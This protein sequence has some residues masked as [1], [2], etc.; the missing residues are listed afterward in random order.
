AAA[1]NFASVLEGST[2]GVQVSQP[3]G[4]TGTGAKVRIR[5]SSSVSLSNE[6]LIVIDGVE[7][8]NEANQQNQLGTIGVGGQTTSRLNDINP[9]EIE[10]I[11][12]LQG[13]AATGLY[14]TAAANG[15]IVITT[16]RGQA[17]KEHWDGFVENGEIHDQNNYPNDY[18]SFSPGAGG[19]PELSN[20]P[21]WLT[22][23][24]GAEC[25]IDSVSHF[26]PLRSAVT[27]IR[28]GRRQEYDL[29]TSGG[30]DVNTFYVSGDYQLENGTNSA[31]QLQKTNGR[32][33]FS[34]RPR[35]DLSLSFSGGYVASNTRLPQNDN[36]VLGDL[37][38]GFLGSGLAGNASN[39]FGYFGAT[40]PQTSEQ[41]TSFADIQ[42]WTPSVTAAYNPLS[43]LSANATGGFD[44]VNADDQQSVQPN[45]V[46]FANDPLGFKIRDRIE[47]ETYTINSNVV[48]TAHLPQDITA[49]S[50]V[51]GSWRR[52]LITGNYASGFGLTGGANSLAA[53]STLQAVGEI[54]QDNRTIGGFVQ[55]QFGWRDKLF[56]TGGVRLDKNSSTGFAAGTTSYPTATAAYVISDEPWFPKSNVLSALKLRAA[57]GQSGLHPDFL[58]AL[59]YKNPVPAVSPLGSNLAAFTAGNPGNPNLKPERTTEVET[60]LDLSLVN[61]RLT[62]ST[63]YYD[64]HTQ[65][66]LIQQVLVPSIGD[67]TFRWINIGKVRNRGL[68]L[69]VT[70]V[71][72]EMRQANFTISASFS[73]NENRLQELGA[74]NGQQ[75][76][77][78]LFGLG[79]N[80]Q[81]HA[82]GFPL[83]GYWQIPY[84]YNHNPAGGIETPSMVSLVGT[85][86]VYMG[87]STPTELAT[88]SPQLTL[89]KVLRF[90]SLF[91]FQGGSKLFNGT[92][93]YRDAIIGNSAVD[94]LKG[95]VADQAAAIA[96]QDLGT[97][98][99]YF[100]DATFWKWR[101]ASISALL[102][103][104]WAHRIF[105]RGVTLT[106]AVRN[107]RT[108]TNYKG[109]D[110]EVSF[111]G[112]ANYTLGDFFTQPPVRYYT[113]RATLNY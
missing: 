47:T 81:E 74:V 10:S 20:C 4:T 61:D 39:N 103:T 18:A 66:A 32:A 14:G 85:K 95:N 73:T 21:I 34:T 89:F 75:I 83:G 90:G 82:Q 40:N 59:T 58:N 25:S 49:T 54:N 88:L 50:T 43:W 55:E 42:R 109:L 31:N 5:G 8:D 69:Q 56:I 23:G 70:G 52:N 107:L 13:P 102:P 72:I 80:T 6:P 27:P 46:N 71:P 26:N 48:A 15:V 92:Q 60:G 53:V 101:E 86:S 19:T 1:P 37:S 110:P 100:Q 93:L 9:D 67:T 11:Q 44:I 78:I 94:Y 65:D 108:W 91:D 38:T 28:V 7:V 35:S 98:G 113:F 68:E 63:T 79:G 41:I 105:A 24:P 77:P 96:A 62:L 57:F 36:D 51:G 29:S 16:K 17:S 22:V 76:Q 112:P 84:T 30:S 2:P 106:F 45:V 104:Q 99:G 87:S 111:N 33:N 64:K 97:L 12:T 3:S